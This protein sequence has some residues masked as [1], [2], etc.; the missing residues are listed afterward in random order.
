[1]QSAA[2]GAES[3][4][5]LIRRVLVLPTIV[6]SSFAGTSIW[7]A[8]NAVVSS[9][10]FRGGN[11]G[12]ED[13]DVALLTSMVQVGFVVGTIAIAFFA[14]ADRFPAT[15]VFAA[16]SVLG[17][18]CNGACAA[19]SSL[20]AWAALR[21]LVGC[22]EAGIYPLAMTVAHRIYPQGLGARL[23]LLVGALTLGTAFPWL[24]KAALDPG[25]GT[26]TGEAG[27]PAVS[28][29][30]VLLLVSA[31]AALGGLAMPLVIGS[32]RAQPSGDK[33]APAAPL[34]RGGAAD[35]DR[36]PSHKQA[37]LTPGLTQAGAASEAAA[38]RS[39]APA[40]PARPGLQ[41]GRAEVGEIW[42][43]R[44]F[45][46]AA[47]GYI[48]HCWEVYSFWAFVPA[49]IRGYTAHIE[50]G[51][52]AGASPSFSVEALSFV[53]IAVG[54]PGSALAHVRAGLH[55]LLGGV[56]RHRRFRFGAVL[57]AVGGE[58][59]AQTSGHRTH[60]GGHPGLHDHHRFSASRWCAAQRAN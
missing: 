42:A 59:S 50:A 2:G 28:Y 55:P 32:G 11:P 18:I 51:G 36:E 39:G 40:G 7:F 33:V 20:E 17:A 26:G 48:G 3:P 9:V 27:G 13:A 46:A 6:F 41:L 4:L 19:T 14:V 12:S 54:A 10:P 37:S 29:V 34:K 49:L 60:D 57:F 30:L 5:E 31:L 35:A 45:R 58:C 53:A 38:D 22:C 23:G 15:L 24:L 47:L 21:F 16:A 43:S 52:V 25:G 56:G 8:P 44:P 1:M